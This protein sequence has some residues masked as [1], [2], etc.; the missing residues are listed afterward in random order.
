MAVYNGTP[1]TVEK[2]MTRSTPVWKVFVL[3]GRKQE[4]TN[5]S[6][7]VK[8]GK[9]LKVYSFTLRGA[10]YVKSGEYFYVI[11]LGCVIIHLKLSWIVDC[12]Y[13]QIL[14]RVTFYMVYTL[15]GRFLCKLSFI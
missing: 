4:V 7:F 6:P 8:I 15:S 1:F 12:Y 13:M 11:S 3:R 2:E 10:I 5:F 14:M 9:N